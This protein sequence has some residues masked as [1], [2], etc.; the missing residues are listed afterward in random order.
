[1]SR[2]QD[3]L[4]PLLND[5]DVAAL[6]SVSVATVRRWRQL[7][8][9]PRYLKIGALV[10]YRPESVQ[11]WLAARPTGGDADAESSQRIDPLEGAQSE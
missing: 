4:Q 8:M 11:E 3:T 2:S 9:G 1:M 10:R 7:D 6:V 5:H